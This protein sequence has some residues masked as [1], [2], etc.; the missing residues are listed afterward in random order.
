MNA[1]A[2]G[3]RVYCRAFRDHL[4][5]VLPPHQGSPCNF[6]AGLH[7]ETVRIQYGGIWASAAMTRSL[8]T[9]N[10]TLQQF[11]SIQPQILTSVLCPESVQRAVFRQLAGLL[12]PPLY[13]SPE[14]RHPSVFFPCVTAADLNICPCW[15]AVFFSFYSFKVVSHNGW[16]QAAVRSSSYSL[17]N[18]YS[19][20]DHAIRLKAD[21]ESVVESVFLLNYNILHYVFLNLKSIYLSI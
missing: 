19:E 7:A 2:F 12:P 15:A 17:N 5:D 3:R 6:A 21:E 16:W 1:S 20:R 13:A 18:I 11:G 9:S 8:Q 14:M 4:P 10:K